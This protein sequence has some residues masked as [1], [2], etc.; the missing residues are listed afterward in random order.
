MALTAGRYAE[1]FVGLENT[2]ILMVKARWIKQHSFRLK[3]M[4]KKQ[5][6]KEFPGVLTNIRNQGNGGFVMQAMKIKKAVDNSRE[7]RIK[8]PEDFADNVEIIVLPLET[9]EI[10]E[11]EFDLLTL[12]YAFEDDESEDKIWERYLI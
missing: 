3:D 6:K 2:I 5:D 10:S 12:S 8:I 4:L 11:R 9:E 7:I 1:E